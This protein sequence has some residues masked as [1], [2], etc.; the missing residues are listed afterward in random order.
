MASNYSSQE[1]KVGVIVLAA[2]AVLAVLLAAVLGLRPGTGAHYR[3]RFANVSGLEA[4]SPVTYGGH[5]VGRVDRVGVATDAAGGL[6][7]SLAVD[8]E[9]RIPRG[10]VATVSAPLFGETSVE[11][12]PGD[13]D[14]GFHERGALLETE[15]PFRM[16]EAFKRA[17]DLVEEAGETVRSLNETVQSASDKIDAV[18]AGLEQLLGEE[19]RSHVAALL[20][21][22]DE[23]MEDSRP[24][25]ERSIERV[26]A[27]TADLRE[28]AGSAREAMRQAE[29]LLADNREDIDALLRAARSAAGTLDQAVA[30]LDALVAGH[31][32]NLDETLAGL[33]ETSRNLVELT[34][35]LKDRPWSLVRRTPPREQVEAGGSAWR[36]KDRREGIRRGE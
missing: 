29:R 28:T 27:I 22:A 4:G 5:Q 26:D 25:L 15:E 18:L 1:I 12:L 35:R 20:E 2:L 13:P 7:V 8:T 34:Q 14:D 23:L 3:A 16:D 33:R 6:E 30:R 32:G 9:L 17:Q 19:N 11:L 36:E 24:A 21:G 10:T 31:R